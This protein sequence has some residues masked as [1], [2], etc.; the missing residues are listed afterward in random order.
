[1]NK[2]I[3]AIHKSLTPE[4]LNKRWRNQADKFC[5]GHCYTGAEALY[6]L[7]GGKSANLEVYVASYTSDEGKCTHWWLRTSKGKILDPT[8]IQYTAYGE[9]PPYHLGRKCGFLTKKP[10]KRAQIVIDRVQSLV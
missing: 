9:Q 1:M 2:L 6:H 10:S 7:L 8:K 4:L 3:K 5:T